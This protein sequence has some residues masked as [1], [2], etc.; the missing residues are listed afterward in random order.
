MKHLFLLLVCVSAFFVACT[1]G[2]ITGDEK[3]SLLPSE[4]ELGLG[5]PILTTTFG[6]RLHHS[7][8]L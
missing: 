3:G 2:S 4:L 6:A 5:K 7:M 8:I 1:A